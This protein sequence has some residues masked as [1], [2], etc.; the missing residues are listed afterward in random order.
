MKK[1]LIQIQDKDWF[2]ILIAN[3]LLETSYI[4]L[5]I[6]MLQYIVIM[7]YNNS[8][9]KSGIIFISTFLLFAVN[10]LKLLILPFVYDKIEKNSKNE[11]VKNFITSLKCRNMFKISFVCV[12]AFLFLTPIFLKFDSILEFVERLPF[13]IGFDFLFGILGCYFVLFLLWKIMTIDSLQNTKILN[14]TNTVFYK[15]GTFMISLY[16]FSIVSTL[17]FVSFF[18]LNSGYNPLVVFGL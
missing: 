18:L 4:S 12:L 9:L 17:I 1:F 8:A 3:V 13:I 15:W 7:T 5:M 10:V 14:F 2:L 16:I 6:I 11:V